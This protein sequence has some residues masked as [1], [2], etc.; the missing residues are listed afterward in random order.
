MPDVDPSRNGLGLNN[1]LYMAML[2]KYYEIRT[3]AEDTAGQILLIEEP[4]AHLHPQLQRIVFASLLN[5]NCQVIASSHGTHITSRAPFASIVVLT[6]EV[7]AKT[8]AVRPQYGTSLSRNDID[9]LERYLDA[10]KSVLLYAEQVILVEGMSEVCLIPIL[11][12]SIKNIDI[13]T[14]GIAV[15]PIHGVHFGVYMPLFGP[16]AIRKKCAVI[17]DGD[18]I[19]SDAAIA[20]DADEEDGAEHTFPHFADLESYENDF[21][22]VFHCRTTFEKALASPRNLAMFRR[23]WALRG[24]RLNSAELHQTSATLNE[25][26][27]SDGRDTV[28]RMARRFG[29]ARFAQVACRYA[30][31][32]EVLPKYISD[33]IEWLRQ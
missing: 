26:E 15:V 28:L 29:K 22:K 1:A 6:R 27:Q 5:K 4:E 30:T 17:T 8:S 16:D 18:L 25:T 2:L 32:A 33:A 9:D 12:K 14:K 10:T 7:A 23:S 20:E 24:R 13:E 3:Q 21:V 19:S 31:E 11:L